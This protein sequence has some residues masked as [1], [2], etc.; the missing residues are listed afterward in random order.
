MMRRNRPPTTPRDAGASALRVLLALGAGAAVA[1]LAACSGSDS[2]PSNG[3]SATATTST[4]TGNGGAGTG[5][6]ATT[7]TGLG[8][9]QTGAGGQSSTSHT[10][11]S[12]GSS[13]TTT[14]AGGSG[15][16]GG[17]SSSGGAANTGGSG[18]TTSAAVDAGA[19]AASDAGPDA[20]ADA[21]ADAAADAGLPDS[22]ADG[23]QGCAPGNAPVTG[24]DIVELTV[25]TDL[26]TPAW[27]YAP[28]SLRIGA[29]VRGLAPG[30][31]ADVPVMLGL[32]PPAKPGKPVDPSLLC[33]MQQVT[34]RGLQAGVTT[35][36]DFKYV[37]LPDD[38]FA[39]GSDFVNRLTWT[40]DPYPPQNG[41]YTVNLALQV[42]PTCEATAE[43]ESPVLYAPSLSGN[44][45]NSLCSSP[46]T[47]SGCAW[48]VPVTFA[49]G[50]M[51]VRNDS[52]VPSSATG[53]VSTIPIGNATEFVPPIVTAET[54]VIAFGVPTDLN[55]PTPA[56]AGGVVIE[57]W[58]RPKGQAIVGDQ[59]QIGTPSQNG[60]TMSLG[61]QVTS[62][63]VAHPTGH[64][65]QL[66]PSEATRQAL[67]AGAWGAVKDFTIRGCIR[68]AQSPVPDAADCQEFD[69]AMLRG[70]PPS[71][72]EETTE[73]LPPN[74]PLK[75]N[76]NDPPSGVG[77]PAYLL[78]KVWDDYSGAYDT[79]S[80]TTHAHHWLQ[81]AKIGAQ[82]DARFTSSVAAIH[83]YVS[84]QLVDA[85]AWGLVQ[86]SG[87]TSGGVRLQLF[88]DVV[89]DK[90]KLVTK[91]VT[92]YA[93]AVS[94]CL[95]P[96]PKTFI[97]PVPISL[98]LCLSGQAGLDFTID[99]SSKV[100]AGPA[101]FNTST[102]YGYLQVIGTPSA[103]LGASV[104][105]SVDAWVVEVGVQGNLNIVKASM[106]ISGKVEWG[107]PAAQPS[108]VSG[109]LSG[110]MKLVLRELGGSVVGYTKTW[111]VF[112][113]DWEYRTYPLFSFNGYEQY[114]P[115]MSGSTQVYTIP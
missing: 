7:S 115:L 31:T 47:G 57:Y 65:H 49:L 54:T 9:G 67:T 77:D 38:C 92:S 59:L 63:V 86:P 99:M 98:N 37:M 58:I 28:I 106:P 1:G 44:P 15:G 93:K 6:A 53:F 103:Q 48:A 51:D 3:T 69:V 94:K 85:H 14:A 22:G 16:A 73:Q 19:D 107:V 101:P 72:L 114:F 4:V 39:P 56:P 42:D 11:G 104:S 88:D 64:T 32:V 76:P 71:S 84:Q 74:A 62:F 91:D 18:G 111:S 29:K 41:H 60:L 75:G 112:S 95:V 79:V 108:A 113:W 34:L 36:T 96:A 68:A 52:V 100:G 81:F 110:D 26:S 61:E 78:Y 2:S 21:G 45:A 97:G 12:G 17:T 87:T 13:S 46:S 8:G 66:Y 102:K 20:A 40:P 27:T 43:V 83:G 55:A 80:L 109:R 105:V 50:G 25:L 5:G 23:G 82:G 90:S 89:I 30:K 33:A 70:L 10:G 24:I 35:Y